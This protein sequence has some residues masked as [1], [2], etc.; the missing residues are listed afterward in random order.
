M[1]STP[2]Q[3]DKAKKTPSGGMVDTKLEV[4]VIPVSDVERSKRFYERL[5]WRLDADF[6]S[7]DEWRVVQMTPPG[8][9]CS[10][11]FGKGVTTTAPGSAQGLM[12]IVDDIEKARAELIGHGVDMSEVFH[13]EG[14][15]SVVG[16]K[17][18]APGK[19]P[20]GRSYSSWASFGDPDG[21]GWLLQEIK[22]RLPGRGLGMDVTTLTDLLREAEEHHGVYEATAPKHHW[23]GWYAGYIVARENGKTSDEAAKAASL[24]ME[25][26]LRSAKS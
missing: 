14:N 8:S 22:T 24:H 19:D 12:L 13:F 18:R 9:P 21:N 23:S 25:G 26:I 11:I 17:G 5:G 6:A 16:T 2:M 20:Q 10:V 1:S 15:L 4:I 3:P 7:G